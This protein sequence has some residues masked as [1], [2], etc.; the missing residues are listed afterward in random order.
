VA[1]Q[2]VFDQQA[3]VGHLAPGM[4]LGIAPRLDQQPAGKA[5]QAEGATGR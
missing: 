1:C 2:V 5:I 4:V 3:H